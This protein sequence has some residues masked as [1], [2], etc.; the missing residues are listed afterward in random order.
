[1][2]PVL[3]D[4]ALGTELLARGLP[5]AALPERWLVE[6]PEEVAAVHA[7][8]RAAGAEVVL[9]CTFNLASPRLDAEP[10]GISRE[11]LA[12]AAVALARGAAPGARIAGSIG[13]TWGAADAGE[14]QALQSAAALALARAGC[15]LLWLE[16]LTSAE[17]LA[18]AAEAARRGGLPWVAT[19]AF[20]ERDGRLAD[21]AGESA[22]ACLARAAEAGACAVGANCV[23]PGAPLAPALAEASKRL[24]V[25]LVAKPSA[26]LPGA[27]VAPE[28]FAAWAV[29]LARA[30]AAWIGGCCGASA[31]HVAAVAAALRQ[32]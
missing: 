29:E 18:R 25:P 13:P 8:H 26:G 19:F 11:V 7:A 28:A 24:S 31:A 1:M 9:T 5:A 10:L 14:A 15:D 12:L 2:R 3:L 4:G 16:T 32:A 30:G 23:L 27:V 21:A 20:R 6:R 17:D 22:E